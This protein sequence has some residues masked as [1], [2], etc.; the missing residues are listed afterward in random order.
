[1]RALGGT[2]RHLNN[3]K[4]RFCSRGN[5]CTC[6]HTVNC[7][8][9]AWRS[10]SVSAVEQGLCKERQSGK[11]T[12]VFHFRALK[13]VVYFNTNQPMNI[14]KYIQP[15]IVILQQH[16]SVTP[17]TFVRGSCNKNALILLNDQ[18]DAQFFF[19][20]V[21]FSSLRISSIQVLIIR[22]FNCIN[23]ISGVFHS[24]R[25][26]CR[27]GRSVETCIPDGY[28]HRVTYTRYRI[29][30]IQSPDDEHLNARNM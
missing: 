7:W 30:T 16:I 11:V 13:N 26:V 8:F 4:W 21:Y 22:S 23:T 24:D 15:H 5:L 17:L 1:M 3:N 14:F 25:L 27:F 2:E 29:D 6:E 20:Y 9:C 19:V 10:W 28:L 18:L 12:Y